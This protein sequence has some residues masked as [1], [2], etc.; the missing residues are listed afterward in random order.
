MALYVPLLLVVDTDEIAVAEEVA[1]IVVAASQYESHGIVLG[2]S[3][4][5][6]L[7]EVDARTDVVVMEY[8]DTTTFNAP[9]GAAPM[10]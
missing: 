3:E 7:T 8:G 9:Q 1:A 2:Y 6:E 5:P 4:G 10:E